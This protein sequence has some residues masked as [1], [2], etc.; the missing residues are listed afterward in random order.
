[1]RQGFSDWDAHRAWPTRPPTD[2]PFLF[3]PLLAKSRAPTLAVAINSLRLHGEPAGRSKPGKKTD[4]LQMPD[5]T[6]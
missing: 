2:D 4:L 3:C 5:V 6:S 1:M